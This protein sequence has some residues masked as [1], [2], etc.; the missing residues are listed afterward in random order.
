MPAPLIPCRKAP[1]SKA[2]GWGLTHRPS[3]TPF[4]ARL[5]SG[6]SLC[7]HTKAFPLKTSQLHLEAD[8][9]FEETGQ[10][11]HYVIEAIVDGKLAGRAYGWFEPGER[12]VLEKIEV[13]RAQRSKGYGTRVIQQLRAKAREKGCRE[14]VIQG[15]RPSNVRAVRLYESMGAQAVQSSAHLL[16]F[17]IAPP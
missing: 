10:R 12:F 15:V 11:R 3:Q 9:R 17:V 6:A 16:A 5:N 8:W 13:E 1:W 2:C 4:A 14:F 7:G